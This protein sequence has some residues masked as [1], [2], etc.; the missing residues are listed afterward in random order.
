MLTPLGE[1]QC[2]AL[3]EAFPNHDKVSLLIASPLRR[4]IYTTLLSFGPSLANGHCQPGVL[5]LPE[6]Q[7]TS[8]FPCDTGS[9]VAELHQEMRE[10][11]LPLNL[12]LLN[13]DWNNTTN[14]KWTPS[15]EAL[16]RRAREARIYIRDQVLELQKNGERD[17][18]VVVVTHGGFLHY[19]TEDWEDS[20][21]YKGES[22]FSSFFLFCFLNHA[23]QV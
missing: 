15:A 13:D 14:E 5:A 12:S 8:S 20:S 18:Q 10:K 9:D 4:T 3:R 2:A 11:S 23:F 6:M 16:N 7:E 21:T 22:S 1:E 17:P 19:F